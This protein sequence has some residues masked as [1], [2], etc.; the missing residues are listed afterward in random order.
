MTT[1]IDFNDLILTYDFMEVNDA[2]Y[3]AYN[4]NSNITINNL[5]DMFEY[6]ALDY[7]IR[8]KHSD[9]NT[10]TFKLNISM[11]GEGAFYSILP[12]EF[13]YYEWGDIYMELE[14]EKDA[15]Q[16]KYNDAVISNI[17]YEVADE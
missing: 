2:V 14:V 7:S 8:Y 11:S 16:E 4:E 1:Q 6:H 3:S 15:Y 5:L 10:I 17:Y 12:S 13:P 9:D